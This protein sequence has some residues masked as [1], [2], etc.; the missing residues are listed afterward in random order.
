MAKFFSS[1]DAKTYSNIN[2]KIVK[3]LDINLF[4]L[5][6]GNVIKLV[7]VIPPSVAHVDSIDFIKEVTENRH[8]V[9]EGD[10]DQRDVDGSIPAFLYINAKKKMSAFKDIPMIKRY[11]KYLRYLEDPDELD[12]LPEDFW[13][14]DENGK[15]SINPDAVNKIQPKGDMYLQLNLALISCGFADYK[16]MP[17]DTCMD[18]LFQLEYRG[19]VKEKRGIWNV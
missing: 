9:V 6:N 14:E 4:K 15:E 7:G 19:A 11:K 18:S 3:I 10:M 17:P 16:S 13:Q 5:D 1:P 8:V 2:A 12:E